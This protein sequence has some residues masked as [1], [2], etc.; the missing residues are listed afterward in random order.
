MANPIEDLP[1]R[2]NGKDHIISAEWFN[3]IRTAI[4]ASLGTADGIATLGPDGRVPSDQLTLEAFEYKGT[5][6]ANT[7]TPSLVDGTGNTGDLYHVTVAGSQDFGSGSLNFK[8]NDTVVY[9]GATWEKWETSDGVKTVNGEAPDA[10]GNVA[11]TTTEVPEG[12]NQYF[13]ETRVTNT[14]AVLANTAKV[15]ADGSIG[16]HSDV[17]PAG[18]TEGQ[19]LKNIGGTWVPRNDDKYDAI[20]TK[21]NLDGLA[22]VAG[23]IYYASDENII[24]SD[25]G[26]QLIAVAYSRLTTKGDIVVRFGP[27]PASEDV[28]NDLGVNQSEI[29]HYRNAG[30]HTE[31]AFFYDVPPTA[32]QITAFAFKYKLAAA[33]TGTLEF[34]TQPVTGTFP[35]EEFDLN[36]FQLFASIDMATLIADN[37]ER[38]GVTTVVANDLTN[39]GAGNVD[40]RGQRGAIVASAFGVQ[41]APAGDFKILTNDLTVNPNSF[42]LSYQQYDDGT[43]LPIA[44]INKSGTEAF[45]YD[46]DIELTPNV[47]KDDRLGIGADGEVLTADSNEPS[48][49]KWALPSGGG[50]SIPVGAMIPFTGPLAN[51]PTGFLL[52]DNSEVDRVVYADLFAAIGTSWGEGDGVNTFNIPLGE[53]V[54]VKGV[55]NGSGNDPDAATRTAVNTGGNTGD[56]VGT[57]QADQIGSHEHATPHVTYPSTNYSGNFSNGDTNAFSGNSTLNSAGDRFVFQAGFYNGTVQTIR[58]NGNFNNN[59]FRGGRVRSTVV[60]GSQ[61]TG[62]NVSVHWIVKF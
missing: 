62:R 18:V 50:G 15:S 22:R 47:A 21:T 26:T 46:F 9:N 36:N 45:K 12:T 33:K 53:G 11:L 3:S 38:I 40:L 60:G 35:T 25:D 57:Y 28:N 55:D 7:N 48:G 58:G 31:S 41:I 8:V 20:D 37:T 51:I 34:Y 49:V 13:T 30:S 6:N 52:A 23:K 39:V 14:P 4:L 42:A 59:S 43:F 10:N 5:Y 27:T 2:L 32:V 56:N 29:D 1:I 17:N 54:G 19:V 16:T 61:T 44:A 24:Y